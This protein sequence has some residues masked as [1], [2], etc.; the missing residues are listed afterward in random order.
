MLGASGLIVGLPLLW[1]SHQS[2][3]S[4]YFFIICFYGAVALIVGSLYWAADRWGEWK[5]GEW[6]GA[7]VIGLIA[8]LLVGWDGL[9]S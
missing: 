7:A 2:E 4:F 6:L 1:M 5:V 8:G 3:R 9:H